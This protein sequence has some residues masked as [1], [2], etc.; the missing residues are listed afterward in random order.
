L[1]R[2]IAFADI[3]ALVGSELGV[4]RWLAISQDRVNLFA[5]A[6]DDHQWIHV[7]VERARTELGGPIAHGF[8]TLSLVPALRDEIYRINDVGRELNYGLNKVRFTSLMR[9]GRQLR[10]RLRLEAISE[11]PDGGVMMTLGCVVETEN[12]EKPVCVAEFIVVA[13]PVEA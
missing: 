13:Y 11:R 8:L 12:Q 9:V 5:D 3:P 4:S 6:T 2:L 10:L 7:D 1:T